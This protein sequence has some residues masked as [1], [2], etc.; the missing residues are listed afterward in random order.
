MCFAFHA[1]CCVSIIHAV[2]GKTNSLCISGVS[3]TRKGAEYGVLWSGSRI[4][5]FPTHR[6]FE[7]LCVSAV[8][9]ILEL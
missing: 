7:V 8:H 1:C 2:R 4:P 5:S 9:V 6:A 3:G